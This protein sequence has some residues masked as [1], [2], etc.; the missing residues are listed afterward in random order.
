MG[1]IVGK[2][3]LYSLLLISFVVDAEISLKLFD[4]QHAPL[5]Q[6]GAGHPFL[7][8]V[9]VSDVASI[10]QAP[11]IEGLDNFVVKNSGVRITSI[12]G[13]TTGK[14]NYEVRIDTPGTY[15]IGPATLNDRGNQLESNSVRVVVG[16][17][18]VAQAQTANK[19]KKGAFPLLRLKVDKK[20]AVVGEQ[21]HCVLRFYYAHPSITL[22]QFIIEQEPPKIHRKKPE[23][24]FTGTEKVDGIEYNYIEWDWDIFPT[25]PGTVT[26]PAYGADY[27][28]QM[29]R[30]DLWGG[31]GR[32]F[33]THIETKRIYSNAVSLQVDPL[34][35]NEDEID[36]IGDYSGLE[37]TA[38]PAIAKQGEGI[39]VAV[40]LVGNGDADRV[41]FTDLKQMP[42]ELKHYQ[43]T[44]LFTPA[45]GDLAAR[46]RF[47][48][49]VQGLKPGSWEI[50]EQK[51]RFYDT[52]NRRVKALT[53]NPLSITIMPGAAATSSSQSPHQKQEQEGARAL[54]IAG[55][56]TT[57][58]EPVTS[59]ARL[60]WWLFVVL[61]VLPIFIVLYPF[62]RQLLEKN[63][64]STY[65]S[66]R[67]QKAFI[68]A[69]KRLGRARKNDDARLLYN[70]FI[71]LFADRWQEPIASITD[72][73]I[74]KR[75]IAA[76]QSLQNLE[77]WQQFFAA[78]TECAFNPSRAKQNDNLFTQ[79]ESW[80]QRLEKSL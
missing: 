31:L 8:E 32:L 27:E 68:V 2:I 12:N 56:Y 53:S 37:I 10:G 30:D 76:Q 51:I 80:L 42:A 61:I 41:R 33:G 47:E 35:V 25:E 77:E 62:I 20:R 26:I 55:M 5:N 19:K 48:F 24:P 59:S 70:I 46:T 36:A 38:Q 7:V 34:G 65:L 4:T 13:K 50:P 43:S 23:G 49:I 75:L 72:E 21:V 79:A 1:K 6:A 44:H 66:R 69:K 78:I 11:K 3:F 15:T 39:V 57:G 54:A 9:S 52:Q 40:E 58:H 22:R 71:E 73:Y 16:Q 67:A 17:E 28:Q 14:Y 63:R 29:D 64:K 18:Q 74:N 60:P 45:E